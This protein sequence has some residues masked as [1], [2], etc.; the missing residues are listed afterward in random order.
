MI[1]DRNSLEITK[2]K[3]ARGALMGLLDDSYPTSISYVVM[4]RL[5]VDAGS[6]QAHELEGI[7]K[8]LIDKDY[9][10]VFVPEEPELRP[11]RNGIIE[12]R[13]HGKDLLEGSI[14]DDP[15]VDF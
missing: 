14:P 8:Y 3:K 2:R 6:A 13:A 15:G 10:R 9:I 7:V 4:E 11:L 12:L 1:K 5:L